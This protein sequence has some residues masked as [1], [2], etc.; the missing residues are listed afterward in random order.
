MIGNAIVTSGKSI[1]SKIIK[2]WTHSYWSHCMVMIGED[3][4]V[5]ATWPRVRIGRISELKD[6]EYRIMVHVVPL[7]KIEATNLTAFLLDQVGKKYDWRGLISFIIGSNV[8]NKSWFFCSELVKE[9]CEKA[10]RPLLRR[11]SSWTTPDDVWSSLMLNETEKG[12]K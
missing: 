5:E 1:I 3:T 10:N 4:F 8:Q 11:K 7:S 12:K 2:K 6:T 9:A